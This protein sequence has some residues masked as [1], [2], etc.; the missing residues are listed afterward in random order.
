[1]IKILVLTD[2][3]KETR[4]FFHQA[5]LI[6]AKTNDEIM[7]PRPALGPFSINNGCGRQIADL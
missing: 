2:G 1:M 7:R 4:R 6:N 3:F 5:I